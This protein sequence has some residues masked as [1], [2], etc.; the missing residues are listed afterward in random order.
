MEKHPVTAETKIS[1]SS[2][3]FK[4]AQSCFLLINYVLF[5]L[6]D[7]FLFHQFF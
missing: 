3:Y 6:K 5:L 1:K 7:N 4:V 2:T